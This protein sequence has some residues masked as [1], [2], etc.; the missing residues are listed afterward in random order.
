MDSSSGRTDS[1]DYHLADNVITA[2]LPSVVPQKGYIEG[3]AKEV[4]V[5]IWVI[6]HRHNVPNPGVKSVLYLKAANSLSMPH[7]GVELGL[8]VAVGLALLLLIYDSAFPHT[9]IMGRIPGSEVFKDVKRYPNAAVCHQFRFDL[10]IFDLWL[11]GLKLRFFFV[12]FWA[13]EEPK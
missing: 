3:G 7:P 9:A 10:G 5:V 12:L 1:I 4:S 11:W 6:T 8:G 13:I 2:W